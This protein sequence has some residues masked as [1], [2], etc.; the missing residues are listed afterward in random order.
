V[1]GVPIAL[2]LN[3][4][5]L[6]RQRR[7]QIQD[8]HRQAKDSIE[9]LVAAC[10]YNIKVLDAMREEAESGRVMHSPDLRITTWE[11]VSPALH[12]T[13]SDPEL[14]QILS[15]HWLRLKRI[16]ALSDEIFAREVA[17]SLPP[18]ED[19][20]VALE[21]WKVLR[22]NAYNLS[23]HAV[24]AILMLERTKKGLGVNGVA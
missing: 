10:Q 15:H 6:R 13:V 8:Q 19:E 21:F 3:E 12:T 9:V 4:L 17:K 23:R 1:L 14:F 24:E 2:A 5:V 11:A 7:L 16:Q 18:I 22:E 20:L